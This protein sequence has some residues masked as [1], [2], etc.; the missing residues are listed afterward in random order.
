MP[1][2]F[3]RENDGNHFANSKVIVA[4]YFQGIIDFSDPLL[5]TS[6][7]TAQDLSGHGSHTA[8]VAAGAKVR[9]SGS[10]GS[11]VTLQ[12]VAPKAYLGDYKVFSPGAYDD[13]ILAAIEA[14]TADGMNVLNMSFGLSTAPPRKMKRSRTPSRPVL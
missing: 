14:A 12:G 9:L 6:Q 7:R 10:G 3:P 5:S 2:G 4:K 13:N 11:P 8:S 1:D